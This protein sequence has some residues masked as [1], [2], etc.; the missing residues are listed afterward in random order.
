ML[1]LMSFFL[2][3][4]V[5]VNTAQYV[6]RIQWL[7]LQTQYRYY[8]SRQKLLT[9]QILWEQVEIGSN[10]DCF[11][12][13]MC[14][15][16]VQFKQEKFDKFGKKR[17]TLQLLLYTRLTQK[18]CCMDLPIFVSDTL[19]KRMILQIHG[20]LKVGVQLGRCNVKVYE[21]I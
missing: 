16:V 17:L 9:I 12:V 4:V 7:L 20:K 3:F 6:C 1:L 18:I 19:F 15:S 5:V 21:N 8:G 11:Q 2:S 10:L 14:I 13:Q